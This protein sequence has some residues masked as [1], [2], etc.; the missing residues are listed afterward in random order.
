M[1]RAVVSPVLRSTSKRQACDWKRT[2]CPMGS[3]LKPG[4]ATSGLACT[5]GQDCSQTR[6]GSRTRAQTLLDIALSRYPR[7]TYGLKRMQTFT[8]KQSTAPQVLV[9]KQAASAAGAGTASGGHTGNL[10]LLERCERCPQLHGRGVRLCRGDHINVGPGKSTPQ[11]LTETTFLKWT[12][13]LSVVDLRPQIAPVMLACAGH[14]QPSGQTRL[15]VWLARVSL[16]E[17]RS[18]RGA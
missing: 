18:T 2:L 14:C 13:L 3:C 7:P 11:R 5:W 1:T 10:A 6:F 12:S 15:A 8:I 4:M 9:S 16:H 17:R